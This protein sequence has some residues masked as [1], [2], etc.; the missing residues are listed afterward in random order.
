MALLQISGSHIGESPQRHERYTARDLLVPDLLISKESL[1]RP[2]TTCSSTPVCVA[3]NIADLA[4]TIRQ[5]VQTDLKADRE[6][7]PRQS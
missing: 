5:Y 2:L 6:S 3:C 1:R 4:F 7:P